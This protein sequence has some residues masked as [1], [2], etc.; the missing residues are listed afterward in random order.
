[1]KRYMNLIRALYFIELLRLAKKRLTWSE[2]SSRLGESPAALSRYMHGHVVP[3][4]N[5]MER[6]IGDLES[7][8]DFEREVLE[9]VRYDNRSGFIDNQRLISDIKFLDLVAK[10]VASKYMGKIDIVLSPAADG[11][12]FATL[13]ANYMDCNLGIIKDYRETAVHKYVEGLLYSEDGGVRPLY[14]P[15]S[16]IRKG[17]RALIVD[18]V[19][20]TGATHRAIVDMLAKIKAR[21]EAISVLIV[22]GDAWKKRIVDVDIDYLAYMP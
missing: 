3:S 14:L 22:I 9:R 5:K 16:L 15:R 8:I 21:V 20:R 12:P 19:I 18:D 10:R 13:V 2:I 4:G 17:Y 7:V 6:L 1:M 11:I